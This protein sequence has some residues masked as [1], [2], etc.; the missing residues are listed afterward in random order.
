MDADISFLMSMASSSDHEFQGFER[1]TFRAIAMK[2][3]L[4]KKSVTETGDDVEAFLSSNEFV[5]VNEGAVMT[6]SM[7]RVLYQRF[8]IKYEMG[9]LNRWGEDQYRKPF[10]ER[11]LTVR[12]HAT[13]VIEDVEHRNVEV[14]R[15]LAEV[16]WQVPP[17]AYSTASPR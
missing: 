1:G 14:I 5:E 10:N 11:G 16:L 13:F 6:M 2:L 9:R 8:R 15:G 17:V 4:H 7:F 12:R 3:T